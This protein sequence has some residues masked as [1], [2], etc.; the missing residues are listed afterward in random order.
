M[1]QYGS[2]LLL[3]IVISGCVAQ[4]PTTPPNDW[5]GDPLVCTPN[6]GPPGRPYPQFPNIAEFTL[7]RVETKILLGTVLPSELTLYQYLYDYDANKLILIKNAN[8]FIDAEYFYYEQRK[9]STYYR[10]DACV[11]S[12][13]AINIEMGTGCAS[14]KHDFHLCLL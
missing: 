1:K 11:V 2:L 13:I 7:E 6:A 8:G 3:V 9:K 5:N 4:D 14:S 12:D 10:G